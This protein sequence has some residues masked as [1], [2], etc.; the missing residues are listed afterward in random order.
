[1]YSRVVF[2]IKQRLNHAV[3]IPKPRNRAAKATPLKQSP[4]F[5]GRNSAEAVTYIS[6]HALTCIPRRNKFAE[7]FSGKPLTMEITKEIVSP[8]SVKGMTVLDKSMFDTIVTV[9]CLCVPVS[10]LG[11]VTKCLK[12]RLLKM[13]KVTPVVE[14]VE[15]DP[16]H[17]SHRLVLLHPQQFQSWGSLTETEQSKLKELGLSSVDFKMHKLQLTFDNWTFQEILR[18]VIPEEVES[19]SG[20]ALVGHIA[21]F[22]LRDEVLPY[23]KLIGE[24]LLEKQSYVKTVVNKLS[25][26]DNTYRNFQMELLAG[27]DNYITQ[28]R[29]N[30]CI[31]EMDFSK[32]YWNSRLSTE[33]ERIV[34]QISPGDLLLDVF[35]GIGPFAIPAGKKHATVYAN[36][37]NPSSFESLE[38]NT[39]LNKLKANITCYNMD[40]RE[41]ILRVVRDKLL[42]FY[43]SIGSSQCNIHIVMNL[44]ALAYTFLDA[45]RSLLPVG[46]S[47]SESYK[48]PKVYCYCFTNFSEAQTHWEGDVKKELA[49]RIVG[50]MGKCITEGDI[51]MRFVRNVA[52][53]KDMM[54]VNF[55]LTPKI[56]LPDIDSDAV[57]ASDHSREKIDFS[58]ASMQEGPP[59]KMMKLDSSD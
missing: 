43:T 40:G 16:N 29:E 52:P 22:N 17:R 27:E 59:K 21:H 20:H 23:K 32:V 13:L 3:I 26:I 5:K 7:L 34:K 56:L 4:S 37:L 44:P 49:Q 24:V 35:A 47:I 48:L 2:R 28:T 9:W 18:A 12:S 30:G 46:T 39:K 57:A 42:E 36:D 55:T 25:T 10:R 41:F 14:L 54:C 38:K 8:A 51:S 58:S 15:N 31:F 50:V 33:H 45:F 19:V 6:S 1:M 53:N 11:E